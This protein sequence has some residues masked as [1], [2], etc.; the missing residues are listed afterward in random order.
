MACN[1]VAFLLLMTA[2]VNTRFL[3]FYKTQNSG[4]DKEERGYLCYNAIDDLSCQVTNAGLCYLNKE[5]EKTLC[6]K[7]KTKYND[8]PDLNI[9]IGLYSGA[10]YG[11][12]GDVQQK[13]TK[14]QQLGYWPKIAM[15]P[16]ETAHFTYKGEQI[17]GTFKLQKVHEF[18]LQENFP[19]KAKIL[20]CDLLEFLEEEIA[21]RSLETGQKLSSIV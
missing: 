9:K 13:A 4:T 6:T 12:S 17:A 5:D 3:L 20:Q 1:L 8:K 21:V 2:M 18:G 7:I 15:T 14:Q 19:Y 16:E 11:E 10:D